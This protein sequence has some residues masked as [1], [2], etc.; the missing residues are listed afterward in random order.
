MYVRPDLLAD[1]ARV[2]MTEICS[3]AAGGE[4][5]DVSLF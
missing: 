1:K 2:S 4:K 3:K 5:I